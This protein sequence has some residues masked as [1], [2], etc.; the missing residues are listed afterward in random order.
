[1]S[2]Y[3][4]EVVGSGF[5]KLGFT[6]GCPWIRIASGAWSNVHP[7]ACC[8]KLG[9]KNM[10]LLALFKGTL[11][12]EQIFQALNPYPENGEF[13]PDYFLEALTVSLDERLDRREIPERPDL[14]NHE[15]VSRRSEAKRVCC[16]GGQDFQCF[17]CDKVF[18]RFHH[19]VQHQFS[20]HSSQGRTTCQ[21]CGSKGLTRNILHKRHTNSAKC[22]FGSYQVR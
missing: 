20:A 14:R 8:N 18:G 6:A 19:L 21:K 7:E 3:L 9:F 11:E 15:G 5:L 16:T 12:Q 1:M 22:R 13:W 4:F 17:Y 10:K 2:I